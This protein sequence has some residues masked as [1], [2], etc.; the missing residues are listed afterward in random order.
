MLMEE[1]YGAMPPRPRLPDER[2]ECPRERWPEAGS[3][4]GSS[5]CFP[6]NEQAGRL[7]PPPEV[8]I[9]NP[10]QPGQGIARF[11]VIPGESA[12]SA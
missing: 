3:A 11:G 6:A 5:R 12:E 2:P 4:P 9:P 7:N 1:A 10:G 8:D